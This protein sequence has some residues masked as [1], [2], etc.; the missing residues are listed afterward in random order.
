MSYGT[1]WT[2][3]EAVSLLFLRHERNNGDRPCIT[4]EKK[5]RCR[6]QVRPFLG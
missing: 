2:K 6:P 5:R 3:G 1:E 4:A